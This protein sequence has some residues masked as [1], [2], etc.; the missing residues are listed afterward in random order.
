M[1]TQYVRWLTLCWIS[2]RGEFWGIVADRS[3]IQIQFLLLGMIA[4]AGNWINHHRKWIFLLG[5]LA[6]AGFGFHAVQFLKAR[7]ST[8]WMNMY[9]FSDIKGWSGAGRFFLE[10]KTG[11]PPALSAIEVISDQ[12]FQSVRWWSVDAYHVLIV[13]MFV[14]P[15]YFVRSKWSDALLTWA[16]GGVFVAG[17]AAISPGNPELYDAAFPAF[18]LLYFI[19]SEQSFRSNQKN[20]LANTLAAL[21]GF[22]LALTE[23]TRP[24]MLVMLPLLVA[25]NLY[26][27]WQAGRA[28]ILWFLVPLLLLSGGWHAKLLIFN[29][30]QLLWSNHSG[31]NLSGGWYP[32]VDWAHLD[33]VLLPEDPPL[34][35]PMWHNLNTY[36][37]TYN[38]QLRKQAV[39]DAIRQ[40]PGESW[41]HFVNQFF[42]FTGVRTDIYNHQPEGS[43]ITVYRWCGRILL[44]VLGLLLLTLG[45]QLLKNPRKIFETRSVILI[46]TA[47]IS[48]IPI[49]GDTNEEARFLFPV[50][51]LLMI[52][53][54]YGLAALEDLVQRV[55]QR[56]A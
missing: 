11:I 38:S 12:L 52:T 41:Q 21:A 19:F 22:F 36:T 10:L 49:I 9:W 26:H 15:L 17:M 20:G 28:R 13:L 6:L 23:L 51:P 16:L 2:I 27:S 37:H 50:L 7:P 33:T 8:L 46:F 45:V 24:F 56:S 40:K 3:G 53:G 44:G 35:P 29:R 30:G 39:W 55:R 43:L 5:V 47:Y 42:L 4:A 1:I 54:S 31:S 18:F 34:R 32:V 14:L 48:F 25:W